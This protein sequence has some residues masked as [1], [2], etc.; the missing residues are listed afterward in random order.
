MLTTIKLY[1]HLGETYGAEFKLAISSPAEAV[2]ALACQLP[3]FRDAIAKAAGYVFLAGDEPVHPD[4]LTFQT[5]K[6]EIKIVPVMAGATGIEAVLIG[7]GVSAGTAA[8]VATAVTVISVIASLTSFA[9]GI[10]QLLSDPPKMDSRESNKLESYSFDGPR[11]TTTQGAPVPVGYGRLMVG[12]AMVS[13]RMY[14]VD[15]SVT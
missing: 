9:L 15:G 11:N 6:R 4:H 13:M 2:R 1:G 10:A 3:G 8:T 7:I 14:A 5:G 12:G